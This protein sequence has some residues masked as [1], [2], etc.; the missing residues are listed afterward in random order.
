MSSFIAENNTNQF[1]EALKS[2]DSGKLWWI[3]R[4]LTM[5][6]KHWLIYTFIQL[7]IISFINSFN[8]NLP[9]TSV[10]L[11]SYAPNF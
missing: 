7:F 11:F 8:Q 4:R 10:V 2:E 3:Q 5:L 6:I 1:S 9:N